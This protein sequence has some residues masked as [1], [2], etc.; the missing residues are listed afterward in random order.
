[1]CTLQLSTGRDPS[2]TISTLVGSGDEEV[3]LD[4]QILGQG[5]SERGEITNSQM[6]KWDLSVRMCFSEFCSNSVGKPTFDSKPAVLWKS[7]R[8]VNSCAF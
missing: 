5:I 4:D 7:S 2:G 6:A 8:N 1:M 3:P